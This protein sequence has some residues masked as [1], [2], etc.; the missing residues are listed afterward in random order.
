M[1]TRRLVSK[2]EADRIRRRVQANDGAAVIIISVAV[3]IDGGL[4]KELHTVGSDGSS[5]GR[6]DTRKVEEA[7]RVLAASV[8][9][10]C[11]WP[12]RRGMEPADRRDR[13]HAA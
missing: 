5:R 13:E 3:V 8:D 9:E 12:T 4:I 11:T 10:A 1:S 6:L 2:E 7:V